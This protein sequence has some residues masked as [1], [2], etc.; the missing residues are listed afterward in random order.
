VFVFILYVQQLEPIQFDALLHLN[1]IF[2]T[3]NNLP[4][5]LRELDSVDQFLFGY[6]IAA[7][8]PINFGR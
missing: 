5:L 7:A 2:L 4:L 6:L 1:P 3:R 8:S